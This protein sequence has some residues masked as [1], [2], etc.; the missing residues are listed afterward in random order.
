M[1]RRTGRSPSSPTSAFRTYAGVCRGVIKRIAPDA[2]V[3]DITH[4]ICPLAVTEGALM[5]A[6]AVPYLP[7]GIHLAVIDPGVGGSRARSRSRP[8]TTG[9]TSAPT[10][11]CSRWPRP[12]PGHGG[13]APH[14]R[15]LPPRPRVADLPRPGRLRPCRG[16][17]RRGPDFDDLGD[18]IDPE[19]LICINIPEPSVSTGGIRAKVLVAD[20]FG[21][22]Q[23]NVK[24][25]HMA[26]F[27]AAARRPGRAAV[28][29]RSVLRRVAETYEQA[30]PASYLRGLLRRLRDRDQRRQRPRS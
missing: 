12:R 30:S 13:A 25:E 17:P 18:E 23:L 2:Q 14:Q 6:R 29:A 10:T 5:L 8:G 15:A 19:T 22:L 1:A 3:L 16:A 4:G 9:S 11:A 27:G 21:N 20:R 7:E 26:E 24:R 28:R